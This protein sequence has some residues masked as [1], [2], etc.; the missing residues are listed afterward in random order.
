MSAN[1]IKAILLITLSLLL[2]ASDYGNATKVRV[3]NDLE[4]GQILT[5]SCSYYIADNTKTAT[6]T[7]VLSGDQVKELSLD[8]NT[9][10]TIDCS[11]KWGSSSYLFLLYSE[12]RDY[13]YCVPECTWSI[14]QDRPCRVD[15]NNSQIKYYCNSWIN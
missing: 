5:L 9:T 2:A 3:K 14:K 8:P 10:T 12:Y 1:S 6:V 13:P 7:G 15:P 4:E 11:F